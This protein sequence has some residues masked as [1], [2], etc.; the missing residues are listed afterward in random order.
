MS[1]TNLNLENIFP[2][3]EL[4][5]T[6]ATKASIADALDV[7]GAVDG[8]SFVINGLTVTLVGSITTPGA[9]EVQVLRAGADATNQTRVGNAINGVDASNTNISYGTGFT[10]PEG[11]NGVNASNGTGVAV[12]LEAEDT[13]ATSLTLTN[14]T[15]TVVTAAG[16]AGSTGTSATGAIKIPIS[17]LSFTE[18]ELTVAETQDDTGDYRKFL[19]HVIR[20]Y[21]EYI[22]SFEKLDTTAGVAGSGITIGAAGT[23]YVVG[24]ALVFSG[25]NPTTTAA[26]TIATIGTNGE[27]T[28]FTITSF[29][30]GYST[31]PTVTVTTAAGTSGV[32]TANLTDNVPGKLAISK[33]SLVENT[34]DGTI[35]RAYTST[36][37]F[38]ES[39]LE[40]ATD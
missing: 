9:N 12:S 2:S 5:D 24:E 11:I 37:S 1:T 28:G 21:Q 3:Y 22:D 35:S 10:A 40:L 13:G 16:L 38:S 15:G 14:S 4:V 30:S 33:G 29:G 39:G 23:G 36:F 7:T 31:L 8:N 6:V 19:Y 32:L 34:T 25:G 20:K 26:G 27:I 17:E 18:N